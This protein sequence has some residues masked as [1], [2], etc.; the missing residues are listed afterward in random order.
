MILKDVAKEFARRKIQFHK[1]EDWKRI[2]CFGLFH[3]GDV[4]KYLIGNPGKLKTFKKGYLTTEFKKENKI[5]WC[6]PTEEFY[7]NFIKPEI[8]RMNNEICN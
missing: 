4:A 5:I 8:E 1:N 7:N 3:W 2:K 6:N